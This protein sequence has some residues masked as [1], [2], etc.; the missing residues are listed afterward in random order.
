MMNNVML[1]GRLVEDIKVED[2]KGYLKLLVTN[3]NKTT[4]TIECYL[5]D[6]L[7]EN[8]EEYCHSGDIVGIKGRLENGDNGLYVQVEKMTF[9]SSKKEGEE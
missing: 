9:L 3:A 7:P 8:L 1:V 4:T 2:K 5:W 6:Q